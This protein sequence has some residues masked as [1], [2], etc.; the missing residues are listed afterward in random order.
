[1]RVLIVYKICRV[2]LGGSA[3]FIVAYFGFV[4]SRCHKD[5]NLTLSWR[6]AIALQIKI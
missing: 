3:V 2:K 1:M 6:E 4:D 5:I